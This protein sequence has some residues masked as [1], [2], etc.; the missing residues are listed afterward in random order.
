ML[1]EKIKPIIKKSLDETINDREEMFMSALVEIRSFVN[2]PSFQVG[3][4]VSAE[5]SEEDEK[6]LNYAISLTDDAQ[7][8]CK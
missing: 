5:W 3:K 1:T 2:S 4:D 6:F 8:K 7:I